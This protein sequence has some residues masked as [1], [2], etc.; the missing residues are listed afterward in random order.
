MASSSSI[1]NREGTDVILSHD[2]GVNR[3]LERSHTC[4]AY[5]WV[6][7]ADE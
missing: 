2:M 5:E 3:L 6:A 7:C 1:S 4:P